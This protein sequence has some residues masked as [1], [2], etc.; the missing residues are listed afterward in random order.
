M[1]TT[2]YDVNGAAPAGPATR[3][4]L[5]NDIELTRAQLGDTVEQLTSRLDVK[6]RA[7]ARVADTA[8]NTQAQVR[9]HPTRTAAVGAGLLAALA[10]LAVWRRRR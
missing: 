6:H 9:Q 3:E 2:P 10:G 4:Q 7:K 5:E 8:A 1:A